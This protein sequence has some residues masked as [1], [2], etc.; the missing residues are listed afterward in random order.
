MCTKPV[1]NLYKLSGNVLKVIA[2][3]SMLIDHLSFVC[4]CTGI[5]ELFLR[6]L[7]GRLAFPIFAFLLV[8]GF[9]H[10]KNLRKYFTGLFLFALLSELPYDL[11]FMRHQGLL[12]E[13]TG[14]NTLFTLSLGLLMLWSIKKAEALLYD[15]TSDFSMIRAIDIGII[16][17]F[18]CISQLLRLDYGFSGIACIGA[19][20]LFRFNRLNCAF[21]GCVGLN[22][23]LLSLPGAF[24]SLLP[25]SRYSGERGKDL[26]YFKYFFY[27]FYP[28]HL[29]LLAAMRQ[30]FHM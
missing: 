11:L 16:A 27:L 18:A 3:L 5:A 23:N 6:H 25:I 13:F 10:T 14:Q 26:K 15:R 21:F 4:G 20:Y 24:L 9:Q 1:Q 17:V 30:A 22:L 28:A 12:P 19:M 2:C 7:I 29:L 8:E